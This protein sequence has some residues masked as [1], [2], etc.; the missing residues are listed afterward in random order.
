MRGVKIPG[1]AIFILTITPAVCSCQLEQVAFATGRSLD[2]IIERAESYWAIWK[3]FYADQTQWLEFLVVD[4]R[5]G[6]LMWRNGARTEGNQSG[7]LAI[8][9]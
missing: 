7:T 2:R 3:A 1:N 9:Q 4:I 5:D 8:P 6:Q